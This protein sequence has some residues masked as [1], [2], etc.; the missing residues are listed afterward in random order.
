MVKLLL[1]SSIQRDIIMEAGILHGRR[2][3]V[4][5]YFALSTQVSLDEWRSQNVCPFNVL[6]DLFRAVSW[7]GRYL[8]LSTLTNA[9]ALLREPVTTEI[10]STRSSIFHCLWHM[11]Q[12]EFHTRGIS[13]KIYSDT[14]WL[15]E[16]LAYRP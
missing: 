12:H 9:C 13:V 2:F 16:F 14:I 5:L 1:G 6:Y 3:V 4:F 8:P 10:S 7:T 15:T 11:T